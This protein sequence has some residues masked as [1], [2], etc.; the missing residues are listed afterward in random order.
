L[1]AREE[2]ILDDRIGAAR[3]WLETYAP[4]RVRLSIHHD[5]LPDAATSLDDAQRGALA[6]LGDSL[7]GAWDGEALQ[8]AI[9][10][11][12][13]A[14]ELPAGRMFAALYLAFLGQPHGPRAGWLL[15]SLERSFVEQRLREA[16]ATDTLPA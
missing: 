2:E 16:A 15:A 3:A 8:A 4:E 11:A 6:R 12:A 7:P 13:R 10:E 9:F 5:R 1:T 14:G